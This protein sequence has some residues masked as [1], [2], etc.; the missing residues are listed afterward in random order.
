MKTKQYSWKRFY[1]DL[2][3]ELISYLK[4]M[5]WKKFVLYVMAMIFL[6]TAVTLMQKTNLGMSS[7]DAL[8][9]NFYENTRFE[10]KVITP[11]VALILMTLAH[12]ISWKKPSLMFFFPL[13]ISGFIGTVID[14]ELTF[15]PSVVDLHFLWNLGYLLIASLLIA[16]ALNM[17]IYC[18]FPLPALDR[19]CHA[20]SERFHIT[21]GQGKYIGEFLALVLTVIIGLIYQTQGDTFYLGFTTIYFILVLGT[22]IDLVRNPLYRFLG[23]QTV[24]MYAD[25]LLPE[26]V[27]HQNK[28]VATRAIIIRKNQILLLHYQTEDFYLLPGGTREKREGLEHCLRR[29]LLEETG[30]KIKVNEERLIIHEYFPEQTYENHYFMSKLKSNRINAEKMALTE[31][32]RDADIQLVWM[33]IPEAIDLFGQY[34]SESAKGIHLMNREFIALITLF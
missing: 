21:F 16:V 20:I 23:I 33:D 15:M 7:W 19:F 1:D 2:F 27:N 17:M 13:L 24:D 28:I 12:L 26:D 9:R 10:Y 22:I 5:T 8:N 11:V 31:E 32:E 14:F 3:G 30:F 29:E 25:D 6:G 18:H 4:V 34:E